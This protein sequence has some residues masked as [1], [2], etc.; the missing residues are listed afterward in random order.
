[1]PGYKDF[2]TGEVLTAADVDSF[3]ANGPHIH[4]TRSATQSIPNNTSTDISWTVETSDRSALVSG[5]VTSVTIPA[6]QGGVWAVMAWARFVTNA[7][8]FRV[9][10]VRHNGTQV[11]QDRREAMTTAAQSHDMF[12]GYI[13][14]LAET[15]TVSVMVFQ[16]SGGALNL[17]G[18][19]LPQLMMSRI[20]T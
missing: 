13:K 5:T 14:L 6:G 18:T 1:M 9:M 11:A 15:D 8:G 7:T 16:N 19:N 2:S 3:L 12:A 4:L 17:D 10:E 20:S